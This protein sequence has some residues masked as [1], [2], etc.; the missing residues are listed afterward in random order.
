MGGIDGTVTSI[1]FIYRLYLPSALNRFVALSVEP[2]SRPVGEQRCDG[3]IC[4]SVDKVRYVISVLS[5]Q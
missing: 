3:A 5:I 4:I 1:G 2:T